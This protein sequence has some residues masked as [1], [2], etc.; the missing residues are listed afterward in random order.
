MDSCYV[1][2]L[3][4]SS[5]N[6][7]HDTSRLPLDWTSIK[8]WLAVAINE[9]MPDATG[10]VSL[11]YFHI[12]IIVKLIISQENRTGFKRRVHFF[13]VLNNLHQRIRPVICI[14][15]G[16]FLNLLFMLFLLLSVLIFNDTMQ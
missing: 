14:T 2:R 10:V 15:K 13:L 1:D 12:Q 5:Y 6:G 16:N 4:S 11:L 3:T 9:N 8:R 7:K